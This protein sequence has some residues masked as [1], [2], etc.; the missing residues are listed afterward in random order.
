MTANGRAVESV[1]QA[2]SER[3]RLLALRCLAEHQQVTLPDL[4]EL[5]CER[6]AETELVD[7]SPEHVAAV[8]SSL[9]HTHVP[10]LAG[11]DLVTYEQEDDLVSIADEAEPALTE[12]RETIAALLG[13]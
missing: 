13:S 11:A 2:L 7:L 1:F 10:L 6:E 12:A 9:Y 4:A 3:R 5:V 8:Y